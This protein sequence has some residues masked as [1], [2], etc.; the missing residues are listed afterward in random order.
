ML[1]AGLAARLFL[2]WHFYGSSDVRIWDLISGFYEEG[3]VPYDSHYYNY[4]PPWFWV[5]TLA[6]FVAKSSGLPFFVAIKFPLILA[7]VFIFLTLLTFFGQDRKKAMGA[8]VAY[9]LNPVSILLSSFGQFDNMSVWFT[10]LACRAAVPPEASRP[11]LWSAIFLSLSVCVKHFNVLLT[12]VFAFRRKALW[13]KVAF[14]VAPPVIFGAMVSPYLFEHAAQVKHNLFDYGL[15][16]GYWGW[17][18]VLCRSVLLFCKYDMTAQ[19]WF[20]VA[21]RINFYVYILIFLLSFKLVKKM[22]LVDSVIAVFLLFYVMTT[23]MSPQYTVWILPVA[24]LRRHRYFY[25][26]SILGALQIMA[27]YYCNYH[28]TL[29]IPMDGWWQSKVSELFVIFRHLT[30]FSCVAW[31]WYL[32]RKK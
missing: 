14:L 18:G 8:G 22:D 2:A 12:P 25:A 30:W 28:W 11:G 24:A 27:F 19:P 29:E 9:F 7:D 20:V 13:E 26:Y 6:G 1:A 4:G 31:L 10:L 15:G 16:S 3:R 5:I 17:L 23:Q 21:D 32:V